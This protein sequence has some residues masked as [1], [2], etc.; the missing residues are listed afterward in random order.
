MHVGAV[1]VALMA[2]HVFL[3]Q[4]GCPAFAMV[5]L[6]FVLAVGHGGPGGEQGGTRDNGC[7]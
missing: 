4:R 2:V 1:G 3:A 5:V 6:V 7:E